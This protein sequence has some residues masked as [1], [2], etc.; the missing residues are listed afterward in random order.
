VVNYIIPES[1]AKWSLNSSEWVKH[2]TLGI[3]SGF[4]GNQ[5]TWVQFGW[6]GAPTTLSSPEVVVDSTKWIKF[7]GDF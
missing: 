5:T 1:K 4:C 3:Y 2:I 7:L 6:M